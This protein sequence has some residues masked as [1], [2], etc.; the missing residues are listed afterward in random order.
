MNINKI[1]IVDDSKT[2]QMII[3]KCFDIAGYADAEYF[4]AGDGIEAQQLLEVTTV[5][6]LVTDLNMP[7]CD[8]MTLIEKILEKSNINNLKIIIVSSI[9]DNAQ[10]KKS[11]PILGAINKP[12]SPKKIINLMEANACLR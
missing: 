1:L 2:S 8:G 5:D 6:L 11:D 3:K 9:A 4:F 7:N 12:L 10:N